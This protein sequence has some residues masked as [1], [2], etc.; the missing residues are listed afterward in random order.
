MYT[1]LSNFQKMAHL[2]SMTGKDYRN[3]V[4]TTLL[5]TPC[6][7]IDATQPL[8]RG[9]LVAIRERHVM[10]D[11]IVEVVAMDKLL[12][13]TCPI[14]PCS[15]N[16]CA[17]FSVL[18]PALCCG[19][20][21]GYPGICESGGVTRALSGTSCRN[22][23]EK[24]RAFLSFAR[25]FVRPLKWLPAQCRTRVPPTMTIFWTPRQRRRST[26]GAD[27]PRFVP[28]LKEALADRDRAR[29]AVDREADS[30]IDR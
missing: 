4:I 26:R 6:R 24:A 16:P 29:G 22:G 8:S 25:L 1:G 7:F 9:N 18:R 17:I 15:T 27:Q 30:P 19:T 13:S 23:R 12:L 28:L 21:N 2:W 11:G 5:K 10:K 3:P 20:A 14:D